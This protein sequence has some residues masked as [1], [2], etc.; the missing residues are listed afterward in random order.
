MRGKGFLLAGAVLAFSV[1]AGCAQQST[2]ADAQKT[3]S[4]SD[5]QVAPVFC[6]TDDTT[7]S[8]LHHVTTC[9]SEEDT[10]GEDQARALQ[11]VARPH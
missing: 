1:T 9:T 6:Q 3:A 8:R 4:A 10:S 11:N 2:V 5:G 7:A